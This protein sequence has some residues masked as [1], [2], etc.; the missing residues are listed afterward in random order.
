MPQ[1]LLSNVGKDYTTPERRTLHAIQEVNLTVERGEF[2]FLTG[3]SGAGKSTLLQ[4]MSCAL[5]PTCGSM[6]YD[7]LNVTAMFSRR[8][9]R[10][11]QS[12]G[13]VAQSCALVRKRTV[14]EN[15]RSALL[16]G[17]GRDADSAARILKALGLVG[18]SDVTG[19]FPAELNL[20]EC[21]RV[22]LAQAILNNPPVL[23][24][25]ELTAN[26]DEDTAW[27]MFLFLDELNRMGTTVI[28]ASSA[29]RFINLMRRRVITLVD[30]RILGDVQRGRFG[31]LM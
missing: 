24:L 27:D 22:E 23:L 5:R 14:G 3:S 1:F 8:R 13:Y 30:G 10:L 2:V 7:G 15:L 26:L 4:I 31:D 29:K 17:R 11:R 20:G 28:M 12:F 16:P 21:R 6:Y 19:R 25:D 9:E 18:L